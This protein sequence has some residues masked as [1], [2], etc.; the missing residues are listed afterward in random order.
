MAQREYFTTYQQVEEDRLLAQGRV[1]D[2]LTRRLFASAGLSRGMRV[3]D[4][5]SGVGNVS[6]LAAEF[7]GPEGRV[8]GVDRDPEA[9]ERAARLAA[10]AGFGNLEFRVGSVEALTTEDGEFDAVVGRGVFMYLA[11]PVL[12]LRRAAGL[13]RSGGLVCVQEPDMT[14]TWSTVDGPTWRQLRSW[15]VETFETLEV[16]Q[17]M[18]PSLFATFHAAGLPDPEL[19][20]ESAVGGGERA[21]AF[22]W[23]NVATAALPLMERLGI[24]T[25]AEVDQDTLTDRLLAEVH[26]EQGIVIGPCMYGA[27]TTVP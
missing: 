17:R 16:D 1:L 25:A 12:A 8:V 20:M 21:V 22:G 6:R 4:L 13:V 14:Y 27:W 26:A 7:V 9:V 3:L 15:I 10:S 24:A 2:P 5:G 11:D 18:G 23:A 19:V